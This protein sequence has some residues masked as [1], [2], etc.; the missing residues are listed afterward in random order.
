VYYGAAVATRRGGANKTEGEPPTAARNGTLVRKKET[1]MASAKRLPK[2]KAPGSD[3]PPAEPAEEVIVLSDDDDE[4]AAAPPPPPR[5]G[6]GGP[7]FAHPPRTGSGR[8]PSLPPRPRPWTAVPLPPPPPQ[9]HATAAAAAAPGEDVRSA[10]WGWADADEAVALPSSSDEGTMEREFSSTF[11]APRKQKIRAHPTPTP[12]HADS[13]RRG[14]KH[15][16]AA[17]ILSVSLVGEKEERERSRAFFSQPTTHNHNPSHLSPISPFLNSPSQS[18]LVSTDEEDA[19]AAAIEGGGVT[20]A[21]P[22]AQETAEV[23]DGSGPG[24]TGQGRRPART[25]T[26]LGVG[27][28]AAAAAVA[29]KRSRLDQA[30][31]AAAAAAAAAGADDEDDEIEEVGGPAGRGAGPSSRPPSGATRPS[32][33]PIT[34]RLVASD[35]RELTV[36]LRPHDT[37]AAMFAAFMTK[38]IGEGWAPAGSAARFVFDGEALSP[39]DTPAGADVE[40]GC[41]IDVFFS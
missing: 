23:D 38:A 39:I 2:R 26:N 15:Y 27:T 30:M 5:A 25:G 32:D 22:P 41:A 3:G 10:L 12:A 17:G 1:K 11:F 21:P 29:A 7:A 6:R 37:F 24:G 31:A 19:A 4:A 40:D 18:D 9:L 36:R 34:L 14:R 20:A 13:G 16:A 28:T 8:R 35:R 33:A